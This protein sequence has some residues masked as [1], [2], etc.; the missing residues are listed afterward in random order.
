MSTSAYNWNA[1]DQ[2]G[3]L[4]DKDKRTC[5]GQ[6]E[7]NAGNEAEEAENPEPLNLGQ[8]RSGQLR[9]KPTGGVSWQ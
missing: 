3:F 8:R 2:S 5:L 9:Q 7:E 6:Q 1:E 4:S